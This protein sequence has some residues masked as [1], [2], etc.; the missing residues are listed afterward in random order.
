MFWHQMSNTVGQTYII[1]NYRKCGER[2]ERKTKFSNIQT[3]TCWV[4]LVALQHISASPPDSSDSCFSPPV[5][6]GAGTSGPGW[7]AGPRA[8]RAHEGHGREQQLQPHG[9][10]EAPDEDGAKWGEPD[11]LPGLHDGAPAG[12]GEEHKCLYSEVIKPNPSPWENNLARRIEK[13]YS[14]NRPI[15]IFTVSFVNTNRF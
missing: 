8:R 10:G 9:W 6:W 3:F 5:P 11:G 4:W 7:E 1:S 14:V 15:I 2:M 12:E 13:M